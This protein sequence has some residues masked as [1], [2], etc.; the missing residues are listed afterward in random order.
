MDLLAII[1]IKLIIIDDRS[2]WSW[3]YKICFRSWIDNDYIASVVFA[4]FFLLL[5]TL[6]AALLFKKEIFIRI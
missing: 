4:C 2:L 3:F 6:A 5:W 1:M